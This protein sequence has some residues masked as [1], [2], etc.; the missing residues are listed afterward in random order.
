M[1][2]ELTTP[3][4]A[5]DVRTIEDYVHNIQTTTWQSHLVIFYWL[6]GG[7][8]YAAGFAYFHLPTVALTSIL[9]G[10]SIGVKENN[11]IA[12]KNYERIF[13]QNALDRIAASSEP[14]ALGFLFELYDTNDERMHKTAA[15]ALTQAIEKAQLPQIM[16]NS[17]TF[18][19][20][21]QNLVTE[22]LT[23][24]RY[25]SNHDAALLIAALETAVK[26][27]ITEIVPKL[28]VV[29]D[30]SAPTTNLK[31]VREAAREA[32]ALLSAH[33]NF[34][35]KAEIPAMIDEFHRLGQMQTYSTEEG[36]RRVW[37]RHSLT[38]LLPTLTKADAALLT[39]KYRVRLRGW[40]RTAGE[41]SQIGAGRNGS[42]FKQ[43]TLLALGNIEDTEAIGVI[44]DVAHMEAPT[45]HEQQTRALAR[46][47]LAKLATIKEKQAV[48]SL[49][50]RASDAPATA[51]EQLLRPASPT[52]ETSE[53]EQ[54]LRASNSE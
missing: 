16:I 3:T 15:E 54:L 46:T 29:S 14:Q 7:C 5:D 10:A 31:R 17:L 39:K 19:E 23:K 28:L 21:L 44:S 49:L 50:L 4:I 30:H 6:F 12:Q 13:P 48:G 18:R 52:T 51:Q 53:P 24:S 38:Y 47:Q 8:V 27:N 37:L 33:A 45:D 20:N 35:T 22:Q 40:L 9:V 34:G 32:V 25:H 43:A 11:R 41:Y 36:L 2:E 26:W 1:P 42:E